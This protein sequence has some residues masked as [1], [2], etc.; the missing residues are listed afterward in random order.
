MIAG[1]ANRRLNFKGEWKHKDD[2]ADLIID[3]LGIELEPGRDA[4]LDAAI[5]FRI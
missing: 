5:L 1:A 4:G 2:I 3:T